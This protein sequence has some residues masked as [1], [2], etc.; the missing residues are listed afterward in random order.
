MAY[1]IASAALF[2][3]L[4][5]PY[6]LFRMLGTPAYRAG[7]RQ[8]LSLWSGK[9][10]AKILPGSIWIQ[11]VSLGEVKS[12][13]PLVRRIRD[14]AE[15]PVFLTSTTATGFQAAERL[16]GPM[17]ATAY[18][19]LDFSPI[20]NR[21]IARLRPRAVVLFETE[22]WPNLIR[23]ASS[24]QIPLCIVNG[25]ISEKSF[26]RY[27]L[28]PTIF[29]YAL[30]RIS[31]AGMQSQRDA[32][33]I[34]ALG[35]R[36]ETVEV[37][38][39]VKFDSAPEP[40]SE[41]DIEGLRGELMIDKDAPVI[42]AGSTHEGEEA[43][44]LNV[45]SEIKTKFPRA[46]LVIAPRHPERFDGVETT[47]RRAGL[48]VLRRSNPGADADSDS[49]PV[50]L[51]DTIGELARVY[52]LA[53]VAFVGGSIARTGGHNIIEPASMGKPVIF[54]P[55]MHHFEDI[56]DAFLAGDAAIRVAGERE[57]LPA[58]LRLLENPNEARTVGE[59]AGR[60]VEIN[61]GATERYFEALKKFF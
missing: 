53:S 61:R 10:S 31:F 1:E 37:C 54:G 5:A 60:L 41:G 26:R 43:A 36:P 52:A 20:V 49:D 47:I 9:D 2:A 42:V 27:R 11:A 13:S 51:L 23:A 21:V 38:G 25:R 4:F 14:D 57:L 45:Y 28:V 18:F 8:R 12:V 56:K 16:S 48:R 32:E 29:R 6:A 24:L 15:R 50:I 7:I 55:F 40:L 34:I 46:R 35:A 39:N 44:V 58:M 3:G 22:L 30:S 19:P 59:A 17:T 33:R